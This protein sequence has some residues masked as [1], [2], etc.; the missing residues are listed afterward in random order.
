MHAPR[1]VVSA[2]LHARLGS[3]KTAA[4]RPV[5]VDASPQTARASA[6]GQSPVRERNLSGKRYT[7][8][9]GA[10][11]LGSFVLDDVLRRRKIRAQGFML[12]HGGSIHGLSRCNNALRQKGQSLIELVPR[13]SILELSRTA[14]LSRMALATHMSLS[15]A[16]H[17][18]TAGNSV[19]TESLLLINS[20]GEFFDLELSC[21]LCFTSCRWP[22]HALSHASGQSRP[23]S[24]QTSPP[25]ALITVAFSVTACAVSDVATEVSA[26]SAVLSVTV[27]SAMNCSAVPAS[28]FKLVRV[29]LDHPDRLCEAFGQHLMRKSASMSF[30]SGVDFLTL[31]CTSLPC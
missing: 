4:A 12:L 18:I 13:L 14:R 9:A 23:H 30:R 17:S 25:V 1:A 2:A 7:V 24:K 3:D 31:N 8:C 21:S 10:R 11:Y 22:P 29:V 27:F 20:S 5:F 15:L 6:I 16:S 26:S 19:F 28:E